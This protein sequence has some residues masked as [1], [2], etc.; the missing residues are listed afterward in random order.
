VEGEPAHLFQLVDRLTARLIAG[1]SNGPA[2]GLTRLAALTTDSLAALKAYLEG[3]RQ[4]RG[5]GTDS[6]LAPL[7]RAIEIDSTFAL[8][9]YRL[10]TVEM[11]RPVPR[12]Q[13]GEAVRRALRFAE[14][15]GDRDRRLIEALAASLEGRDSDAERIYRE[16][17]SRYPD[18]V[19]ASYQLGELMVHRSV[20]LGRSWL[21]ARVPL[22]RVVSID[23]DHQDALFHLAN[24]AARER[25]LGALDSLTERLL[26]L[27][28]QAEWF[29]RG[30]RAVAFGDSAGI[31]RFLAAMQERSDDIAQPWLGGVTF[32]T[33][34]LT[35]GR[36]L[37]R[38]LTEP[39]RS[40][41]VRLLAHV[42]L[43][44]MEVMT[45]RWHAAKAELD[46]AE[47]IDSATALEYHA[48]LALWP[49]FTLPRSELEGLRARLMRSSG[50]AG[51]TNDSSFIGLHALAH[52]YLRLYLMGLLSA[53]LGEPALAL[54]DAAM[55]E[56]EAE[57]S[58][59]PHFVRGLARTVHAEV[60]RRQG[61]FAEALAALDSTRSGAPP[62][63]PRNGDSPFY[64]NEYEQF[65]RAELL[66][67]L[68]RSDEALQLYRAIADNL[69]HTGAPA[70]LRMALLYERL[71]APEQA[72][73][74][75]ARFAE[76][77]RECDPELRGLIAMAERRA[78]RPRGS[79]PRASGGV[80][81][82][83]GLPGYGWPHDTAKGAR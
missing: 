1:R 61:R 71:G 21:D 65:V 9:H 58:F 48:L 44:E 57:T 26:G 32:Y 59:A 66:D 30:Q 50:R 79:T 37:W 63:V 19:E 55:L 31:A 35:V 10:A 56:R 36:R 77:W 42:T 12:P 24:I 73:E 34:D 16:I 83:P 46:A 52:P 72:A 45:G 82:E 68:G 40:P 3:E 11:W 41:G 2:A 60:A 23:P 20:F 25:R 39:S 38:S 13:A 53:R 51:P 15:L 14:R 7:E 70:Q 69:F 8:A 47:R 49:L 64:V 80:R 6:A 18:D 74:H 78:R 54:R 76:L 27:D 43:A 33:G 28:R 67:T 75:Y 62:E 81:P 22:E 4:F 17:V 29:Y 5:G